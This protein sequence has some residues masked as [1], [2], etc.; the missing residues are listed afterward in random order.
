MRWILLTGM[1][2]ALGAAAFLRGGVDPAQWTW[3]AAGLLVLGIVSALHR[4]PRDRVL[5]AALCALCGYVLLQVAPLPEAL[6]SWLSPEA[7]AIWR[8]AGRTGSMPLSVAPAST[9]EL[10]IRL[11]AL[12]AALL[13]ARRLGWLFRDQLWIA[14]APVVVVAFLESLIGLMQFSLTRA[15][16]VSAALSASGT[17]VN[18]NH[19]AGLLE[20]ALPVALALGIT[21]YARGATRHATSGRAALKASLWFSIALCLLLGVVASLSRMGF[22]STLG[23][24]GIAA[25]AAT[26]ARDRGGRAGAGG[27]RTW[28]PA[29]AIAAGLAWMFIFLPTDALIARFASLAQT[30]ELGEDTRAQIWR[31]TGRL[32]EAYPVTGAGL[33][34]YEWALLKYKTAAP[35]K[36]VDFAHNDY[37]QFAAEL[38]AAGSLL[39]LGCA[40]VVLR[41]LWGAVRGARGRR[42]W[43]LAVGLLGS[44]AA[45]A[46]H[47]LADFNLYIPAN[48]L[49][50][51]WVAGLA[52]SEAMEQ[53]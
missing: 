20:T 50:V 21:F 22:L 18:R 32:I 46:L 17:Y 51:A 26:G 5:E 39:L 10:G 11:A 37:L 33:G 1:T 38:G 8:G 2:A 7:A 30:E 34:A 49:A 28:W 47:S 13:T 35:D 25:L 42:N 4:D 41:R 15:Q 48:A 36:T 45:M 9:V 3:I 27:W 29:A 24:L 19:F 52:S 53:R 40:A 44:L 43:W 12:A 16:P 31:D 14:A 23:G 6:V